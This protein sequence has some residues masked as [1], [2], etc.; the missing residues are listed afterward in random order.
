MVGYVIVMCIYSTQQMSSRKIA[1]K[2]IGDFKLK[3]CIKISFSFFFAQE[4]L[5]GHVPCY[6]C[7][8]LVWNRSDFWS[9]LHICWKL[10]V[11]VHPETG[12]GARKQ[13]PAGFLCFSFFFL[14]HF[15]L[16]IRNAFGGKVHC[17]TNVHPHYKSVQYHQ[18]YTRGKITF[19]SSCVV[20]PLLNLA[21]PRRRGVERNV[22][23]YK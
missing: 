16:A 7:L 19:A 15:S 23:C 21:L 22:T 18:S 4:K 8:L 2:N 13:C 9:T 12:F 5:L 11:K 17:P 3:N 6:K 20:S 10:P 1:D 14:Q